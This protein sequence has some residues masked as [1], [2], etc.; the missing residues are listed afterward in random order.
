MELKNKVILV[1]GASSGIGEAAARLF[2]R[3][4]AK[5]VLTARRSDRLSKLAGEIGDSGGTALFRAGDITEEE[6]AA[7]LV[8][9]AEKE[10]GGLDGTFNNAGMLGEM[11]ELASMTAGNWRAVIETN[12]MAAFLQA[13]HQLPAL[14]RRG[15]GAML[16]TSSFVGHAAGM[17]GM[18]AYAASKAG[19]IGM[20]Q[21]LACEEG[22]NGIRVN[23]LL[24]GGTRTP[25]A[26]SFA[27]DA[28]SQSFVAGLHA[29]N[30]MASPAEIAAAAMFLLSDRSSFVT[31]TAT[32][33]D[34]GNAICKV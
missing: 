3:E 6:T 25:M 16:F 13:R 10:F 11:T 8:E 1:T 32:L 28:E 12:L 20:V 24:P 29:L 21:A 26:E 15:G 23:A 18:T 7:A 17:P 5:L 27:P 4:G 34:G 14:R 9:L 31:G 2:S 19:L 22:P 30:R 33:A